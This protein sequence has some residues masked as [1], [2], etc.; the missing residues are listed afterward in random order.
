[1]KYWLN[2]MESRLN[3]DNWYSFLD[4]ENSSV[5]QKTLVKLVKNSILLLYKKTSFFR[6]KNEYSSREKGM[7]SENMVDL[8]ENVVIWIFPCL[9]PLFGQLNSFST[10]GRFSGCT[11]LMKLGMRWDHNLRAKLKK[12]LSMSTW[13]IT[14]A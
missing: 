5:H 8:W 10:N 7:T 14:I 3:C 11:Y 1:M 6:G 2:W 12:C 4:Q 9:L 13:I